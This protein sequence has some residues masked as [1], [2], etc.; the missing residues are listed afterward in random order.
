MK[1]GKLYILL[2]DHYDRLL[3]D[4]LDYYRGRYGIPH[5]NCF[6]ME[7]GGIKGTGD[8]GH[9][10]LGEL[11]LSSKLIV[12]AHGS[13]DT[14]ELMGRSYHPSEL[15]QLLYACGLREAGLISFKV[16]YLG[17]GTFLET[18]KECAGRR[19]GVRLGWLSAYIDNACFM[20]PSDDA[21]ESYR[22]VF[23]TG[24]RV[25]MQETNLCFDSHGTAAKFADAKRV[26]IIK[27]NAPAFPLLPSSRFPWDP[28]FMFRK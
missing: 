25:G 4:E 22:Q 23:R 9:S 2:G 18:F 10:P 11:D 3:L 14:I 27:G 13:P 6:R 19:S 28:F 21:P 16:C 15:F 7:G 17:Q 8:N 12:L 1:W 5:A 20:R 26:K 24:F